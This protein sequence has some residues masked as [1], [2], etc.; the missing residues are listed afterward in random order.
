MLENNREWKSKIKNNQTIL[1]RSLKGEISPFKK[2]NPNVDLGFISPVGEE[3][4][5]ADD[6]R[7]V[8]YTRSSEDSLQ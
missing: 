2:M 7:E 4:P 8:V 5:E 3:L 6:F 1:V